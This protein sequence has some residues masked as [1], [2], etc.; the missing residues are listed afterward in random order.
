MYNISLILLL[1][2]AMIFWI[3]WVKQN[4]LLVCGSHFN[5]VGADLE[6]NHYLDLPFTY[7]VATWLL[8]FQFYYIQIAFAEVPSEFQGHILVSVACD[9][10]D[11]AF[12]VCTLTI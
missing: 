12:P 8:Y 4:I 6:W 3:Y 1:Y 9:I 10:T 11:F 2:V 5:S 7:Y